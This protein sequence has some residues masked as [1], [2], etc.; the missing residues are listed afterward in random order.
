MIDFKIANYNSQPRSYQQIPV[1]IL[2]F[3]M[4]K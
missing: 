3:N 4:H 2:K 1:N